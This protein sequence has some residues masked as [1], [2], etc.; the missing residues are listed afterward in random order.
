MV[1]PVSGT[2]EDVGWRAFGKVGSDRVTGSRGI[3]NVESGTVTLGVVSS[4]GFL[5]WHR[6]RLYSRPSVIFM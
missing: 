2:A 1:I 4:L 3:S 6:L 5:M